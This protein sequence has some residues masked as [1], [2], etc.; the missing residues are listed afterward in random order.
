MDSVFIWKYMVR[1]K[2]SILYSE[3]Y[4]LYF[5]GMQISYIKNCHVY[6]MSIKLATSMLSRYVIHKKKRWQ[7][8]TSFSL[9]NKEKE[10]DLYIPTQIFEKIALW[11]YFF[12]MALLTPP[13]RLC[14]TPVCLFVCVFVCLL[15]RYLKKLWNDFDEILYIILCSL[16]LKEE[17]IN[18]WRRSVHDLWSQMTLKCQISSLS[19]ISRQ[20]RELE[21]Q[22]VL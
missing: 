4:S 8:L 6:T 7:N 10:V 21:T 22:L 9:E 2:K 15:A 5:N 13:R 18:F 14:F 3:N 17:M 19:Q 12:G 11:T 20:R 16:W 1:I